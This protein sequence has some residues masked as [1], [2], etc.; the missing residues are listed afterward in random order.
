LKYRLYIG[1]SG[2]S[3]PSFKGIFYPPEL[4]FRDWLRYYAQYLNS[5]EINV[6]FYRTPRPSTLKRWYEE[7][8]KDF[9]FALKAPKVITHIKRLKSVE[10]EI[11]KFL[12][13][14]EALREKARFLLFQLPPNLKYEKEAIS[15]FLQLMPRDYKIALEVRN[16]SFHNEEFVNLLKIFG[17]ALCLSDCAGK[18]PSWY[19]VRTADFLY[20]RLHGS[21]ELY[22]SSYED[23]ELMTLKE[24]IE[25]L[26][27][28]EVCV[29]FDNT[30]F[31]YAISNAIRFK[32]LF[33]SEHH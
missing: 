28:E 18:Y 16:S 14:L 17:I 29:Y 23:S 32:N 10:E 25:K 11:S 27:P 1:T 8:P 31:G 12:K 13:T 30:V 20:I 33:S 26:A 6:T 15:S 19:E 9:V 7:T 4:K 22:K 24:K 21:K 5:V 2:W 3:Y